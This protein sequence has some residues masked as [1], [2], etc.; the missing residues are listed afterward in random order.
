MTEIS[1]VQ[2]SNPPPSELQMYSLFTSQKK[3]VFQ[4]K[5]RLGPWVVGMAAHGVCHNG[6]PPPPSTLST[7][8]SRCLLPLHPCQF[9]GIGGKSSLAH[10]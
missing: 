2:V 5:Q 7:L 4:L 3:S 9:F 6:P 10:N 1:K 8:L